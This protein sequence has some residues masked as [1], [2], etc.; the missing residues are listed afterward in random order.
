MNWMGAENGAL[1]GIRSPERLAR[2]ESIY[3][4]SY[5]GPTDFDG[6]FHSQLKPTAET[7][8]LYLYF[9]MHARTHAHT[10]THTHTHARH[11]V[12]VC[13]A[14]H[15]SLQKLQICDLLV[16]YS[17]ETGF[18]PKCITEKR[19]L[20]ASGWLSVFELRGDCGHVFKLCQQHNISALVNHRYF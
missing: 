11:A 9:L 8:T 18:L 4:L 19:V 1:T 10:H 20:F 7:S 5:S 12:K 16:F 13:L 15:F 14:V 6:T 17:K 2:R 3:R